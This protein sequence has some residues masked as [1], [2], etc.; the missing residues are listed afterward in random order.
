M[1]S[2]QKD[3]SSSQVVILP[4]DFLLCSRTH[5]VILISRMLSFLIQIN[6]SNSKDTRDIELTRFHSRTAPSIGV[7]QYLIRL[8][9]YSSLEPAVLLAAVYY[10]DLLSAVYPQFTL[11]S[12]TV[13]RFLLTATTVAS[14]GLCDSFCTNTHYSK[15]GGVQC[16]ELNILENEFLERVKYKILPRDNNIENCKVENGS[17]GSSL[18]TENGQHVR[19]CNDGFN[20]LEN[21]YK[22]IVQL[23][24]NPSNSPDKTS[25]IFF[26]LEQEIKDISNFGSLERKPCET[27]STSLLSSSKEIQISTEPEGNNTTG[28]EK[29]SIPQKR[30]IKDYECEHVEEPENMLRLSK[31]HSN[32]FGV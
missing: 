19:D 20:L 11:N 16:S 2:P 30:N 10:I 13:H 29:I 12:L 31:K 23:V 7:Y 15:V 25:T 22:K 17:L 1:S 32:H 9:K 26:S 3:Q 4:H 5:L 21:Y 28:S 24:G 27:S 14:K 6:D 8:T 18:S